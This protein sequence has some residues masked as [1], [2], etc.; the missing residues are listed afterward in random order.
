MGRNKPR[1]R[2]RVCS[3]QV[4]EDSMYTKFCCNQCYTYHRYW[5]NNKGTFKQRIVPVFLSG[6]S[7][8]LKPKKEWRIIYKHDNGNKSDRDFIDFGFVPRHIE[9]EDFSKVVSVEVKKRMEKKWEVV[10]FG[11]K[12]RFVLNALKEMEKYGKWI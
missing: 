10:V 3:K 2:C 12:K 1:G 7:S 11:H 8:Y 4:A 5:K 6:S 9:Q